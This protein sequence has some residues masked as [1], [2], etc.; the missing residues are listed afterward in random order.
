LRGIHPTLT[1]NLVPM[2]RTLLTKN[3]TRPLK[4]GEAQSRE[5]RSG[6]L[7][8]SANRVYR[9]LRLE[10]CLRRRTIEW[11]GFLYFGTHVNT[12]VTGQALL[13]DGGRV[14]ALSVGGREP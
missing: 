7:R 12:Y 4:L 13:V 8:Q 1:L 9:I 14:R 3:G 2:V 5:V 6:P 11:R 10:V